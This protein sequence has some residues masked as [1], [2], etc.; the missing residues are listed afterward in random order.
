V[1]T[2]RLVVLAYILAAAMPP[3]GLAIG[4]GL[5][6]RGRSKHWAWIVLV[7]IVAAGIWA[8][9][10]GSGALSSTNEGY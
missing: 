1:T 6:A 3:F 7:S 2:E 4:I 10:I 5:G 8:V 9:I